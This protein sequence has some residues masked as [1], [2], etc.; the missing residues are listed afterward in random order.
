MAR[1]SVLARFAANT[2]GFRHDADLSMDRLAFR[3]SLHRTQV[4]LILRGER[5][6]TL[7]TLL[8]LCGALEVTPNELLDGLSWDP[9]PE[10]PTGELLVRTDDANGAATDRQR[11]SR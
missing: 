2:Q 11:K 5:N 7:L 10:L 9:P 1:N 8:K 6:V 4:E 3:A